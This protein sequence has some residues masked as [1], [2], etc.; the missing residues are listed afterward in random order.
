M[1]KAVLETTQQVAQKGDQDGQVVHCFASSSVPLRFI[2]GIEVANWSAD[3]TNALMRTHR[4]HTGCK[5]KHVKTDFKLR[6]QTYVNIVEV[7]MN[8]SGLFAAASAPSTLVLSKPKF[9]TPKRIKSQ[10]RD[11]K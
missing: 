8:K 2:Y 11:K 6:Q 7:N 9:V 1:G 10:S 4:S 5:N 3:P